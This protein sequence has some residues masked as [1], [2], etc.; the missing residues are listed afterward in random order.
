MFLSVLAKSAEVLVG[1]FKQPRIH[2]KPQERSGIKL[3]ALLWGEHKLCVVRISVSFNKSKKQKIS[4]NVF[5]SLKAF[6]WGA[7]I[8]LF[9]CSLIDIKYNGAETKFPLWK[10]NSFLAMLQH[11][12]PDW[13]CSWNVVLSLCDTSQ[14]FSSSF[15]S[16]F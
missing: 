10:F 9:L 6:S 11:G 5:F 1:N 13:F 8:V 15:S 2:S 12:I 3:T 14:E 4:Q 7:L 16:K